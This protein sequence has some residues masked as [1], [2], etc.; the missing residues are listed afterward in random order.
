MPLL[1]WPPNDELLSI[2]TNQKGNNDGSKLTR[3]EIPVQSSHSDVPFIL[4]PDILL[5]TSERLLDLKG[6]SLTL[7]M[8]L[9]SGEFL[10]LGSL[11]GSCLAWASIWGLGH[12]CSG[13]GIKL[14]YVRFPHSTSL[15]F[16]TYIF[17]GAFFL[18]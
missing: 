3:N 11:K 14:D 8:A 6:L 12:C 4:K 15:L 5:S 17:V 7:F 2:G 1:F 18:F 10:C 9:E 16:E 13:V